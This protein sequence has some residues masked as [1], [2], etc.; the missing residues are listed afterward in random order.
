MDDFLSRVDP[1]LAAR[2]EKYAHQDI[3]GENEF[4]RTRVR[5]QLFVDTYVN[6]TVLGLYV[7][8]YDVTDMAGNEATQITRFVIVQDDSELYQNSIQ[9][10][11]DGT[12]GTFT[13]G[14]LP[15][16]VGG[17]MRVASEVVELSRNRPTTASSLWARARRGGGRG[18]TKGSKN[19]G[20]WN[21]ADSIL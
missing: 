17:T 18:T 11:Y 5:D 9:Q 1:E 20:T 4:L 12:D 10:V 16:E 3:W 6:S 14:V 21:P 2:N 8:T 19:P 7:I 13:G 15:H